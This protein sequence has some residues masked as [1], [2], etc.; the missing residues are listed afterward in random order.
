MKPPMHAKLSAG[1]APMNA[2]EIKPEAGICEICRIG[3]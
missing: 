1:H 2:E 3:G